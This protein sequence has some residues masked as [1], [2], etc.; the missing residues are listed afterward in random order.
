MK[1]L[2]PLIKF[3]EKKIFLQ[4]YEAGQR[5]ETLLIE[6]FDKKRIK[7]H[8][9]YLHS[10]HLLGNDEEVVEKIRNAMPDSQVD[11]VAYFK[12]GYLLFITLAPAPESHDIFKR[13]AK[14][15]EQTYTRFLDLQR[16]EAQV[17]RST[18]RSGVGEDQE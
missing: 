4:Y 18:D 15:F 16:A 1:A 7:Q 17:K 3:R 6:A 14:E 8:Y 10:L 12:Y 13:F 11:H 9:D 5:G 2:Y